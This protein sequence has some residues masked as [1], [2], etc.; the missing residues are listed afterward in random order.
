MPTR[1]YCNSVHF[2][3]P[4]AVHSHTEP[5]QERETKR[6]ITDEINLIIQSDVA[7]FEHVICSFCSY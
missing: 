3:I 5:F 7:H 1:I 2:F 4:S 6:I